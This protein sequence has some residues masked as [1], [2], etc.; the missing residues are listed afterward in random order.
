MVQKRGAVGESRNDSES[1]T[2]DFTDDTDG[3]RVDEGQI[4]VDKVHYLVTALPAGIVLN[5][6]GT[7]P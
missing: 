7:H 4:T 2:M 3:K 5:S 1:L 6:L